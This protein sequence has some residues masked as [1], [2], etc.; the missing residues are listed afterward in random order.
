[1]KTQILTAAL[2]GVV[3]LSGCSIHT[4]GSGQ[5]KNGSPITGSIG[6][7]A[8]VTT[9]TV[10]SAKGWQCSGSTKADFDLSKSSTRTIPLTCSNG[11]TGN[12]I[13]A[14]NQFAK[15]AT[16]TFALSNGQ[17]GAVTFGG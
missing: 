8:N 6:R 7:E 17:E 11:A 5:M 14:L 2:I 1:M 10:L 9:F 15:Q 12:G 4:G 3:G 16:M 13:V